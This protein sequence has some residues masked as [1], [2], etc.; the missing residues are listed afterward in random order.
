MFSFDHNTVQIILSK[1]YFCYESVYETKDTEVLTSTSVNRV[2]MTPNKVLFRKLHAIRQ[3]DKLPE[4]CSLLDRV[5]L[6][7]TADNQ[8]F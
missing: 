5:K 2:V 7:I 4:P 6:K 1:G 3:A 8:S